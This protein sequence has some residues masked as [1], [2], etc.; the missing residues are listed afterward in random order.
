MLVDMN[1]T[2]VNVGDWITNTQTGALYEVL[3]VTDLA[4]RC[5]KIDEIFDPE[6]KQQVDI[7]ANEITDHYK[8]NPSDETITDIMGDFLAY[9]YNTKF[10]RVA[11]IAFARRV[12]RAH[13]YEIDQSQEEFNKILTQIYAQIKE[14]NDRLDSGELIPH[15]SIGEVATSSTP[16][17]TITGTVQ[18]PVLNFFLPKGEKGDRGEQGIQGPQGV[19]GEQ[20]PK[21]DTGPQGPKGDKGD[22]GAKGDTGETG[23]QGEQGVQG[24][25]GIPGTA[26]TITVGTVTTGAPGSSAQITNSGTTTSAVFDFTIPQGPQGEQGIQGER[27]EQGVPGQDGAKG[28]KGDTGAPG[29]AATVAVGTVT[30]LP[31]G[32][33]P[34]VTNSGTSMSAVLNFGLVQGEKGETGDRGETGPQGQAG[35]AA[36]I[37]VGTVTTLPAGSDATFDNAGTPNAALFNIGIPRG[38]KGE[39]GDPGDK[40]ADGTSVVIKGTYNS[41]EELK[42]AHPT[43]EVGDAYTIKGDLWVWVAGSVND[44]QNVGPI[45]GPKGDKGDTGVQGIPGQAATVSVGT[46]VTGAA[47]SQ[48]QI[49][50]SGTT[51]SAVLDFTIPKG[52]KGDTGAKGDKGETGAKGDAATISVGTVTS[53]PAGSTPTVE[54]GGTTSAAV[55]NFGLVQGETGPQGPQGI[56]GDQGPKGD[57]GVQGEQGETGPQGQ[58]ATVDVG[59]VTTLPAG[60]PASVVNSGTDA[61]AVFDFGIPQGAQGA[62]GTAATITVGTVT[63]LPAGSQPTIT[64]V[65]TATAARFDFGI[66]KGDKGDQGVQGEKGETGAKGDQGQR[67]EQ[68]VP[69]TAATIAVGTVT[70]LPAGSDASVTN[71]GTASEAKFDFGIPQGTKG[72]KGNTGDQGPKGDTGL[73][74]TIAVG[75]VRQLDPGSI[76]TVTN[77]GSTSN[78]VFDF[79]IPVGQTGAKG[80]KGDKG[81]RGATGA[82]GADGAAATIVVKS[83]TTLA[84]GS[85]AT[86]TNAGTSN[87]A[88]L[89]FGIPKGDTPVR[90]VDYW[91]EAD[92][93]QI[94][95]DTVAAIPVSSESVNG[96]ISLNTVDGRMS[97]P[98]VSLAGT[99]SAYTG[100]L[101]GPPW[102]TTLAGLKGHV[103]AIV[104]SVTSAS[105]DVTLNL[106]SLGAKNVRRLTQTGTATAVPTAGYFRLGVPYL[107]MYDG[108]Q[109]VLVGDTQP[110]GGTDFANVVGIGSGGTGGAT[111]ATAWTNIGV[112]SAAT[113][114]P[115]VASTA[116]VGTST[117]WAREDHV[118]PVQTTVSGNAGTATKLATAHGIWGQSFDGSAAVSGDMSGV[119]NILSSA[120]NTKTVG[121]SANKFLA[122]YATTFYGALSGN[123]TSATSATTAT[124]LSASKTFSLTGNATGSGS[125]DLSGN[126]SINVTAVT[127]TALA[128]SAKEIYVGSS[129][130]APANAVLIIEP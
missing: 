28:D 109:Y 60:T 121:T 11:Y 39:K 31:V 80:D 98:V 106:N 52:D 117:K 37:T 87:A 72:D 41:Y 88:Q 124:K 111:Q 43:G 26:A 68:G 90:G 64:N 25:Q 112:P 120:T 70:T 61:A 35:Q 76:P 100:T 1:G 105:V 15:F 97:A 50:N 113:A 127:A 63:S 24:E 93:R 122:M 6:K 84:P 47:G 20:G 119:G 53:L 30:S 130:S 54:N 107:V 45:Q 118:H 40:G 7:K 3:E 73:A 101:S 59:K 69:G 5:A 115:K 85:Q 48:A 36:T 78:A 46:V 82:A 89:V 74:A 83:T 32:S 92:Q 91:T 27:G 104:P 17:V 51:T 67:G 99:S 66:P 13:L 42:A 86:V 95:S 4:A 57:Q 58:A 125:G 44:W 123:A 8:V 34:T 114:A 23:P 79:G 116:A 65:G 16:Q 128:A 33:E 96:L 22:Q 18:K 38:E 102:A 129:A 55:L 2:V 19:Q 56:P 110:N 126:I 103:L 49:V 81:D 108:T 94:V 62:A 21:G 9:D 29:Q 12:M 10:Y 71:V 14:I 77:A 75:T